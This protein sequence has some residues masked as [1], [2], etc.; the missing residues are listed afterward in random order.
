MLLKVVNSCNLFWCAAFNRRSWRYLEGAFG[1]SQQFRKVIQ[2]PS[3]SDEDIQKMIAIR[4]KQTSYRLVYDEIV[5]ATQSDDDHIGVTA[6]E[7]QFF[8]LLWGQSNG[9][10]RA[11]MALW[12]ASLKPLP[13]KKL[14][15]GCRVINP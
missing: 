6:V 12:L 5:R 8:R 3:F 4:H 7:T 9:N 2:V 10:P 13:H 15:V 1:R 14:P 11:A